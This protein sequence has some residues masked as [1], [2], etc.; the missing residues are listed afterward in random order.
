MDGEDLKRRLQGGGD[1]GRRLDEPSPARPPRAELLER[2][3]R[4]THHHRDVTWPR[5]QL[6]LRL[7]VVTSSQAQAALAAA[8]ARLEA[9]SLP[10]TPATAEALA[11]EQ[12]V[13]KLWRAIEELGP[14]GAPLGRPLFETPDELRDLMTE[15]ERYAL[16]WELAALERDCDP[17]AHGQELDADT[18]A[19]IEDALKKKDMIQLSAFGSP[20]LATYMLTTASR[21]SD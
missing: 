14:D 17:L 4:R 1:M 18:A 13:Q 7:N 3:Q 12:L 9:I 10:V 19:E 15:Q 11:E 2:I 5:G 8:W 20:V 21:P 6:R 16:G